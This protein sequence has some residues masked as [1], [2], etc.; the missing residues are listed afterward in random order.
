MLVSLPFCEF[1]IYFSILKKY[2]CTF[3]DTFFSFLFPPVLWYMI[4]K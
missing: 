2:F 3:P 1:D 4:D